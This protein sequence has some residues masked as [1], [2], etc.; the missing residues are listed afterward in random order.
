MRKST[1]TIAA[2]GTAAAF[3]LSAC[4]SDSNTSGSSGGNSGGSTGSS[5]S[6]AVTAACNLS[7]PP[8]STAKAP[9]AGTSIKAS[10]KVGV[11]LPDTTS[12]A[13]YTQFDAP[14][15]K[16]AF[17]AG[18]ATADIQNAQ[19]DT[20]K[21]KTIAQQMI[22]SGVKVLIIDSIDA[23][24]GAAVE[25]LATQAGVKVIDYDRVNL[26][27]TAQYYVSFDNEDVGRQQAQ[28]LV[29]CLNADGVTKPKI[30]MMNGG[31]DVDNNA[32][33]FRKGAL[34]VF[35]PLQSAGKL[36]IAAQATVKGWDVNNAAPT[37]TQALTKTGAVQGVLAANDDIANAVITVLA[38]NSAAGKV[39]VTG[40]DSGIVGLQN[41]LKGDQSMTIFKDVAKYEADAASKLALALLAGKDPSSVGI[42]LTK[43]DDPKSPSHNI[44]ALLL[45]TQVITQ[46]Q[47][48]D[49][50]AAGGATKAQVCK[51]IESACS[52][53]GI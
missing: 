50:I 17:E 13:R 51:G 44:Q 34:S 5:S 12:S 15:L 4:G 14:L 10:G 42:T 32:V 36:T 37:F 49:V 41:V 3:V 30:I 11:I 19:G 8:A 28:T 21:F 47:V 26:G 39:A 18:G 48:K 38:K 25:Q 6:G 20:T 1:L 16:K 27:G 45:P 22:G 46:G 52:K 31:T 33:L 40:Q 35:E 7:N 29:D 23:A 2:I 53:F 43:F 9:A 24:S